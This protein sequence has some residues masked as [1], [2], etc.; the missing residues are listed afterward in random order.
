MIKLQR[1]DDPSNSIK[2]N[3]DSISIGRDA[4]N[5]LVLDEP[6][7]SDFHA[8]IIHSGGQ[9]YI[10]DLL[11]AAGTF[12]NGERISGRHMLHAWDKV[13]L[14]GNDWE[15]NDSSRCHPNEWALYAQSDL[16]SRQFFALKPRTV[17]GRDVSCDIVIESNLLS[18]RHTELII[19]EAA[20]R[21]CDLDSR[22]GSYLNG[23]RISE[24]YAYPGDILSFD[25]EQFVLR[26]PSSPDCDD[27]TAEEAVNLTA[28]RHTRVSAADTE[29]LSATSDLPESIAF[30]SLSVISGP[31]PLQQFDVPDE[32]ISIGRNSDNAVVLDERSVS[33]HHALI[34]MENGRW[35]IEDLDSMN[36]IRVN[37][38]PCR[39]SELHDH[40]EISISRIVLLF[41]SVF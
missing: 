14:G 19:E 33:K 25:Q 21:V 16:L 35:Y 10:V 38:K 7:V 18:R 15:V 24:A 29:E 13:R 17:I 8:E 28:V 3:L 26:G 20:V 22:N 12:V 6:E 9:L 11:S 31:L 2:L 37:D 34:Y 27:I 39:H 23:E 4:S 30:V 41:E 1:C 36:G 32:R 5:R 40:D